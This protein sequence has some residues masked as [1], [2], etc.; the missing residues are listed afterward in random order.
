MYLVLLGVF[1]VLFKYLDIGPVGAWSWWITLAPFAG[2]VAW[3]AFAD[4]TGM[5]AKD[6]AKKLDERTQARRQKNLEALGISQKRRR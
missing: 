1:L 3:W 6:Q 2:A 4:G 5:T